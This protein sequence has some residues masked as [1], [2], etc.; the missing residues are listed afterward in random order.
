MLSTQVKSTIYQTI[1][2]ENVAVRLAIVGGYQPSNTFYFYIPQ[3][4]F[5]LFYQTTL[6]QLKDK[7]GLGIKQNYKT[8]LTLDGAKG[9]SVKR[10]DEKKFGF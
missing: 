2:S 1:L 4:S 8:F 9:N 3:L 10:R 5:F 6:N 7:V